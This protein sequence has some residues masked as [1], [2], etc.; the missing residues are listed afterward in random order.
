MQKKFTYALVSVYFEVHDQK[1]EGAVLCKCHNVWLIVQNDR[2]P[3]FHDFTAKS[4]INVCM[5]NLKTKD[6]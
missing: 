5:C 6:N 3:V 4:K 1:P 2:I